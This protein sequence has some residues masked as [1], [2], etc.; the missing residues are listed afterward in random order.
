MKYEVSIGCFARIQVSCSAKDS[1]PRSTLGRKPLDAWRIASAAFADPCVTYESRLRRTSGKRR[2]PM[3]GLR[4][5]RKPISKPLTTF[6]ET[7]PMTDQ[8]LDLFEE[9]YEDQQ[10]I[11]ALEAAI[12]S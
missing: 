7:K 4:H 11:Q 8:D 2:R 1:G 10:D 12:G 5:D 9:E 6:L 3:R